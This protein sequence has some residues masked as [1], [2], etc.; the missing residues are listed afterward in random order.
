MMPLKLFSRIKNSKIALTSKVYPFSVV[1]NSEIK[2]YSYLSYRCVIHNTKIGKYC[3]IAQD[4]KM[5]LGTHP[6]NYL[7]TSPIFYSPSNPLKK[8]I[9]SIKKFNNEFSPI[10]IGH[11]VWIGNNVTI[12]DG[13]TI[14]NGAIIGAHSLVNKNVDAYSIV[15]GVPAKPIKKRFDDNII[16]LLNDMRWWDLPMSFLTRSHIIEVF[17]NDLDLASLMEL[18][19]RIDSFRNE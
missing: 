16:D 17:S 12:L 13:V 18:K 14:N 5:G 6:I 4:V 10:S 11:D 19:K 7:S 3:S 2:D 8:E 1:L 9:T 15:G